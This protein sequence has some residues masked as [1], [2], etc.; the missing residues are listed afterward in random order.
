MNEQKGWIL[1][2]LE[3][4]G[5]YREMVEK[6]IKYCNVY[7]SIY[8]KELEIGIDAKISLSQI[9]VVEYLLENEDLHQNMSQIACRLGI[10]PS[11]FSK[12]INRLSQK[13]FLNK[14]HT[15]NNRKAVIIRV[16]D[17]GREIYRQY[18]DYIIN[19]HF[20][21]MFQVANEIPK[22]YIPK[23][24]KMLDVGICMYQS[25]EKK[26]DPPILIQ[27]DDKPQK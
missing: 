2:K 8:N 27:I 18:A 15:S 17:Y 4:M 10:S 26:A 13:G 21:K 9:Q 6:L 11:A 16:T 5:D 12:L 14:Y 1:L 3:W 23:I 7:A 24:A 22:E 20:S 25:P 19:T